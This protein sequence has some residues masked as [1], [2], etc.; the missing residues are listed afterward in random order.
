MDSAVDC[1]QMEKQWTRQIVPEDAKGVVD[2]TRLT[3]VKVFVFEESQL[4]PGR[5]SI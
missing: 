2:V 5:D 4:L 1:A 3:A